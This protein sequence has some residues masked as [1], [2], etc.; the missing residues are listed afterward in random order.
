MNIKLDENLPESLSRLLNELGHT[1][2]TVRQEAL[3]GHPDSEI[4]RV[5]QVEERF[6]I[7]QD[8]GFSDVRKF[9]PGTHHGILLLRLHTPNRENLIQRVVELF[10]EENVDAWRACLVVA[11][12]NKVRVTNP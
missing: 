7:T 5:V 6:P 10:R 9:V 12:E 3:A 2:H 8:L 4:W 11:T 1:V